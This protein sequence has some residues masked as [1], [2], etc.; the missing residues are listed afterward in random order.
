LITGE[1]GCGKELIAKAI[2]K[3]SK[4]AGMPMVA[5]NCAA[6]PENLFESELFGFEKGSFTG[7]FESK[8]G[9]FELADGGTLFLDEVGCLPLPSQSK[10]LRVIQDGKIERIGGV[11]PIPADIRLICATNSDLKTAVANRSF[12][13]DLFYRLNVIPLAIPPLRSRKD[14]IKYLVQY[15]L[16][17][18][19]KK[20][21]K[22]IMT[23][24]AGIL[25]RFSAYDWPGN[26]RELENIMERLVILS[27]GN[28]LDENDL[29]NE[30]FHKEEYIRVPLKEALENYEIDCLKK[31]LR[32]AS[33]NQTKAADL[34]KIDRTTL[35][36]KMRKYNCQ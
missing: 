33:G 15:F 17:K 14:D 21:G 11:K 10:L 2:H 36:S 9:K 18:L 31:A 1:T 3:K 35:L 5:V 26:I 20:C 30:F 7:A 32:S 19:N 24:N 27:S 6:I 28:N 12:R 8:P 16:S 34:L 29:P 22:K 13:E 4:R 23:M 25:K